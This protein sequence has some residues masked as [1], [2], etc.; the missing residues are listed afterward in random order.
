MYEWNDGT[1]LYHYGIKGQKWGVRRFQNPDGTL[2]KSGKQ[3]YKR[4][5]VSKYLIKTGDYK[6]KITIPYNE[7]SPV[8]TDRMKYSHAVVDYLTKDGKVRKRDYY[9]EKGILAIQL[10][11]DGHGDSKYKDYG[12][13]GEHCHHFIWNKDGKLVSKFSTQ[14][15]KLEREEYNKLK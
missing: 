12:E 9:D 11:L 13:R 1:E 2:T 10:H 5:K 15:T 6:N 14:L 3:R 4:D 8:R 7:K